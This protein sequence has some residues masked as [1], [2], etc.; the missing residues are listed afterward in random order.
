M[1][2]RRHTFHCKTRR[3]RGVDT[4]RY[5][6]LL[7]YAKRRKRD[8][9]GEREREGALTY[10]KIVGTPSFWI[11]WATDGGGGSERETGPG[12]SEAIPFSRA[13]R[14]REHLGRNESPSAVSL[15]TERS[16]TRRARRKK[17]KKKTE[18]LLPD[19]ALG[20]TDARVHV[21]I[22]AGIV[23]FRRNEG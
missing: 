4:K 17:K 20:Y 5:V 21:G 11:N 3:G 19:V 14:V 7:N 13:A 23:R 8:G 12:E 22:H 1:P 6:Y 16:P 10:L 9:G 15:I 2:R 18:H